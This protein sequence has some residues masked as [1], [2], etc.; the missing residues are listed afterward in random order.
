MVQVLVANDPSNHM[1]YMPFLEITS[2][3]HK[4]SVRK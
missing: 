4:Q 1:M 2:K 3:A